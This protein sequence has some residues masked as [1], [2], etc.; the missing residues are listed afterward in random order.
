MEKE[1]G[2]SLTGKACCSRHQDRLC[3]N[4]HQD[5]RRF[6]ACSLVRTCWL[7]GCHIELRQIISCNFKKATVIELT[8]GAI[9]CDIDITVGRVRLRESRKFGDEWFGT[10]GIQSTRKPLG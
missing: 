7:L 3:C 10:S 4:E 2:V 5:S 6:R 8:S 1:D 9:S